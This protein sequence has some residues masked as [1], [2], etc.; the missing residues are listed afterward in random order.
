MQ[1]GKEELG[2]SI[3]ADKKKKSESDETNCVYR[4]LNLWDKTTWLARK[5][6]KYPG[7]S[8]T[9]I[10]KYP[11]FLAARLL[12]NAPFA[13]VFCSLPSV[14]SSSSPGI[15]LSTSV[16]LFNSEFHLSQN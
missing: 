9:A 5:R 8:N 2:F 10:I 12:I 6:A 7:D 15:K 16:L 3:I 1:K 13:S 14:Y 4:K 11:H